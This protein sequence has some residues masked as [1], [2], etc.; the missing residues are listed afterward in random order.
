MSYV[1]EALRRA[2][3]ER[4]HGQANALLLAE[5]GAPQPPPAHGSPALPRRRHQLLVLLALLVLAALLIWAWM[6]QSGGVPSDRVPA[7]SV[8]TRPSAPSL[9][10]GAHAPSLE[11][12]ESAPPSPEPPLAPGGRPL[13]RAPFAAPVPKGPILAPQPKPEPPVVTHAPPTPTASNPATPRP[14]LR[15]SGVTYSENPAHRM[16]IVNGRVVQEG[17]ELEPG[18]TLESIGP[19]SAVIQHGATR[20]NVNY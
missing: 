10:Q 5:P 8:E 1:L 18:H 15:V 6:V 17:Q 13:T 11:T 4:Q 19:R 9:T 7:A 16:L 3:A 12:H 2:D 20:Y 14:L